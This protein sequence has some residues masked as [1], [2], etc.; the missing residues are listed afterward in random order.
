[1]VKPAVMTV[2]KSSRKGK[3]KKVEQQDTSLYPDLMAAAKQVEGRLDYASKSSLPILKKWIETLQH[4]DKEMRHLERIEK[5][6]GALTKL[7][8]DNDD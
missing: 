3:T 4:M 1:M 2:R 8:N 5:Y 7:S 6:T